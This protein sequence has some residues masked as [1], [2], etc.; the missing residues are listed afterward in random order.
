M[1]SL[2]KDI[3]ATAI[4]YAEVL[5]QVL[6]VDVEIVDDRLYR[7]AGT[8]MFEDKLNDYMGEEGHVYNE[9]MR[10]E[11][12]QIVMDP[13]NHPICRFCPKL[14]NCEETFEI[15]MSIKMYEEVIGVI[16]LICFTE[17]QREHILNNLDIYIYRIFRA[18]F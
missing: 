5:S 6:R 3:Q 7:I 1:V 4:K 15:S 18:N 2:L 16:G 12:R 11:E 9:V 8:G 13:G 14:H 10:S 17:E